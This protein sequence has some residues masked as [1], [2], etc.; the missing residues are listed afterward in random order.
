LQVLLG[1][2]KQITYELGPEH[3]IVPTGN[4]GSPQYVHGVGVGVGATHLV[5]FTKQ[6]FG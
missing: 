4:V 6:I 5:Q 2:V 3:F 1:L